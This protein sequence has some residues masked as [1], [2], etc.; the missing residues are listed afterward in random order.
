M[1]LLIDPASRRIVYLA[2]DEKLPDKV[3]VIAQ[4]R[5]LHFTPSSCER[6]EYSRQLPAGIDALGCWD[7]RYDG[8]EIL[9]APD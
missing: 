6:V 8:G 7:F 2:R 5:Q 9:P 1:V 4:G 3:V